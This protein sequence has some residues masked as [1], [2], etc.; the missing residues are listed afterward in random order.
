MGVADQNF[1]AG[2]FIVVRVRD[3]VQGK[4]RINLYFGQLFWI[5]LKPGDDPPIMEITVMQP[6]CALMIILIQC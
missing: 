4:P 2:L 3:P 1:L 6:A 5:D